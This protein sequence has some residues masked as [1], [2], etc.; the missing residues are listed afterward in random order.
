[1]KVVMIVIDGLGDEPIPELQGKTP[2]EVAHIPNIHYIATRG[3]IGR[4]Q[5][6]FPGF[7]VESMVCIMGLLGYD[8][9]KYYPSGRASFEAMAKGIPLKSNDIILRC[10]LITIDKD[11]QIIKDF[12]AG[13]IEDSHAR[14]LISQINL[15]YEN[16][17]VI[18]RTKLPKYSDYQ[19]S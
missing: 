7:P 16:W 3:Q 6:T 18:P 17:G 9:I 13:L 1:M 4:I 8:P 12:T 19:G 11:K 10:N 5:T 2:L 15:P 14:A